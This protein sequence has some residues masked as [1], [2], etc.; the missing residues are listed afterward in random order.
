MKLPEMKKAVTENRFFSLWNVIRDA[1]PLG[2]CESISGLGE[3]TCVVIFTLCWKLF[4]RCMLF[5]QM[6]TLSWNSGTGLTPES[7]LDWHRKTMMRYTMFYLTGFW[8]SLLYLSYLP[9]L[10]LMGNPSAYKLL[11]LKE[12]CTLAAG[13]LRTFHLVFIPSL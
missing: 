10:K 8:L 7:K 11:T 3:F 12:H 5:T 1:V 2:M 4:P 9:L 6:V 13:I